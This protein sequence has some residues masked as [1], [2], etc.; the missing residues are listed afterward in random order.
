MTDIRAIEG[1]LRKL[2]LTDA[3]VAVH[4][5]L[6]SFGHVVGGAESVVASLVEVCA[7]V[8]MP[9]FCSIGRTGAPADDRPEQNAWDYADQTTDPPEPFDPLTFGR[10]S[11]LDVDE[12]G[13]IPAALLK[14]PQ[15]LRSGHPS[16]SWAANGSSAMDFTAGHSPD[17]PNRPLKRLSEADGTILLLGVDLTECTAVHL[18]EEMAGRRPFIRWVKYAD[19]ITRRVREYG[20]SDA[21]GRLSQFVRGLSSACTIG[22]CRA[23]AYPLRPFLSEL[24][25]AIRAQPEITLCGRDGCRC[26]AAMLRVAPGG[27]PPGAPTDPAVRN[28]RSGFLKQHSSKRPTDG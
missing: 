24:A 14:L 19:G 23:V 7:T 25:A 22:N 6:S 20:C 9:T 8:L 26:Q 21:F 5:S 15:T 11:A 17:D 3:D 2:G 28:Y 4:S 10:T 27:C 1:G 13:Q 12:M 16:V 18:A